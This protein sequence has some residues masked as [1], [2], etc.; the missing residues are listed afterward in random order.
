MYFLTSSSSASL[1]FQAEDGIRDDLVTGVQTCALPIHGG[2]ERPPQRRRGRRRGLVT[3]A[4][5]PH[6]L[7]GHGREAEHGAAP[8]DGTN[9]VIG[10]V[11]ILSSARKRAFCAGP[12]AARESMPECES[13]VGHRRRFAPVRGRW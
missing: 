13:A 10:H 5:F 12:G 9:E 7:R 8:G 2:G 11:R 3:A 1:F 6:S 4:R